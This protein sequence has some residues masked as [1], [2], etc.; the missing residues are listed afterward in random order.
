MSRQRAAQRTAVSVVNL[1]Y[2]L[3]LRSGIALELGA[4]KRTPVR[5]EPHGGTALDLAFGN[6]WS[7]QD[8][9]ESLSG[10][11]PDQG[12]FVRRLGVRSSCRG[13]C[14]AILHRWRAHAI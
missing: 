2:A 14:A 9:D 5:T 6:T 12:V 4:S 7:R 13:A 8:R 11:C 10:R 1:R 3:A